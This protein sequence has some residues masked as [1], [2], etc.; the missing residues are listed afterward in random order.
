MVTEICF[1]GT[2]SMVPTKE[3]NVQSIHVQ[4]KADAF[5]VDCGE[6]TQRQMNI[7]G[8]NR[9]KIKF[10]L[11]SHWHGDHVSGLIGLIQ[12]I[13][14][15]DNS[16]TLHVYGPKGTTEKMFH[17]LR[18]CYFN[19][20]INIEIHE[21]EPKGIDKFLETDD[22]Y[23]ESTNLKHNIPCLAYNFI[24]KDKIKIDMKKVK[25][26]GLKEGKWLQD[27]QKNKKVKVN[28]K[29]LSPEDIAYVEKGKK[30][31][32][33]LD[34][35]YTENA[36]KLAKNADLLI[37]ESVY[38]SEF[39]ELAEKYKHMTSEDSAK[40]ALKANAKRLILTHFSQRYKKIKPILDDAKKIFKNVDCAKDFMN[41]KV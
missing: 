21:L 1:L 32:F 18:S 2:S 26:L 24:E 22:Y 23:L 33:V 19:Q 3:R 37:C 28:G 15:K 9:L 35:A 38:S 14:E 10:V 40:I 27:I 5:L 4:H 20:K 11:I 7:A 39:K 31:S 36:V 34:S 29:E 25:Q 41:I 12:T 30:I 17:L 13:C 6:G 16:F 8:L